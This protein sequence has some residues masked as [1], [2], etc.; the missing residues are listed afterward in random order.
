M[1]Y[2]IQSFV[3]YLQHVH[4]KFK[5]IDTFNSN[6]FMIFPWPPLKM[7]SDVKVRWP[8][9]W[10]FETSWHGCHDSHWSS[11][12]HRSVVLSCHWKVTWRSRSS[13]NEPQQTWTLF[14]CYIFFSG[15]TVRSEI[16]PFSMD[17]RMYRPLSGFPGQRLRL[18]ASPLSPSKYWKIT[19]G[20]QYKQ[21]SRHWNMSPLSPIVGPRRRPSNLLNVGDLMLNDRLGI[22]IYWLFHFLKIKYLYF[23]RVFKIISV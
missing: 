12:G 19:S 1:K 23:I 22:H 3:W 8:L 21:S 11:T 10:H 9:D 14:L 20:R 16:S 13:S 15:I 5:A 17:T 18:G 4:S 6:D 2:T 7:A